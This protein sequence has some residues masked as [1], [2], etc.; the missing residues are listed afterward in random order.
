MFLYLPLAYLVAFNRI[1]KER[2]SSPLATK[3]GIDS[4]RQILQLFEKR[5][6]IVQHKAVMQLGLVTTV[7]FQ[8]FLFVT[9]LGGPIS[10][11]NGK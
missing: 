1:E 11:K 7:H 6:H 2:G 10:T 9:I 5:S 4:K 3:D 8:E